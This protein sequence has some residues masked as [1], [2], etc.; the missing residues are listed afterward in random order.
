MKR[1]I[2]LMAC[3]FA[4]TILTSSCVGSFCMFNKLAQWN[5]EATKYKFVNELL[6]IV[7]SPAY[8][9]SMLADGLILNTIEF[10][11]GDNPMAS[12]VGKTQNIM[13]NDG[14][15]Y[16]VKTLKNGYEITNQDGEKL[17]LTYDKKTNSWSENGNG[18]SR[19]LFRFNNDGTI[20]ASL[21][22]GE[23]INVTQDAAGL[24]EARMA[25]YGVTSFWAM[26]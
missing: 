25:M 8:A 17:T 10:W 7:I 21:P 22:N 9:I 1:N 16:A 18:I 24:Y 23:K 13:G 12:N 26:R 4:A 3:L 11:S 14:N 2:K 6:Y 20:Q 15:Y 19:E 5:K